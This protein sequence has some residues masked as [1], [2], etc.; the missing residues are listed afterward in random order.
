MRVSSRPEADPRN[1]YQDTG[2]VSHGEFWSFAP[3]ARQPICNATR[4]ILRSGMRGE[5]L[6]FAVERGRVF[7][8]SSM[9][10]L[11][12]TT[13]EEHAKKLN[14][15]VLIKN[16]NPAFAKHTTESF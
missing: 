16:K 6:R 2:G 9:T 12:F 5:R 1:I 7:K 11:Y 10:K 8:M 4:R 13:N 3:L 15:R 14:F